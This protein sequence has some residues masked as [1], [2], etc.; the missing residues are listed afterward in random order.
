[1]AAL[2]VAISGSC[3]VGGGERVRDRNLERATPSVSAAGLTRGHLGARPHR[4]SLAPLGPGI[5]AL[6]LAPGR[7][8]LLYVPSTYSPSRPPPL[9][10]MLHGAGANARG[11]IDPFLAF[12]D[13]AGLL[14]L[15]PDSR[16]T[17][18]DVILDDYRGDVEFI[19]RA[20]G[21]I[22]DRFEV[23]ANRMAIEGFS[24]GASY[25]LSL[26]LSNGELYTHVFA[27]S[28][29]FAVPARTQG[30]PEIFITHGIQDRVLP[31]GS[32]S[33]RFVPAL[34]RRYDIRY[35]EFDGGHEIPVEFVRAAIDQ[36][37]EDR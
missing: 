13:D 6:G 16:A 2:L 33:R 23:D 22:F 5:H 35:E 25:A 10:L 15:A 11:G 4:P 9:V 26:G 7:D 32:T 30:S 17:T 24:D 28:P 21:H 1:M 3:A 37:L 36:L 27:F 19:D 31:I 20:L 14:L 18:W 8:G 29:G 12:A 34:Q